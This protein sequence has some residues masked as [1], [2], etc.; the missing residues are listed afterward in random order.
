[1]EKQLFIIFRFL[2]SYFLL[3]RSGSQTV[4][5]ASG[6]SSTLNNWAHL[7]R[8]PYRELSLRST[9]SNTNHRLRLILNAQQLLGPNNRTVPWEHQFS[10]LPLYLRLRCTN[11]RSAPLPYVKLAYLHRPSTKRVWTHRRPE[12]AQR[13]PIYRPPP[14]RWWLRPRL[15]WALASN[16]DTPMEIMQAERQPWPEVHLPAMRPTDSLQITENKTTPWDTDTGLP[17]TR[18][19]PMLRTRSQK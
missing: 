17:D 2:R 7:T 10:T 8:C 13:S 15:N 19:R 3:H 14:V 5:L 9:P 1:M 4:A 16:R 6:S 18:Q 12:A 11:P